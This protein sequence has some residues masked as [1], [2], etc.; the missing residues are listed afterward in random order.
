MNHMKTATWSLTRRITLG[1][2]VLLAVIFGLGG[3]ALLRLSA[4]TTSIAQVA[5]TTVPSVVMLD[6]V[7]ADVRDQFLMGPRILAAKGDERDRLQNIVID[8]EKQV[9]Q[10]LAQYEATLGTDP[11]ERKLFEDIKRAHQDVLTTRDQMVELSREGKNAEHDRMSNVVQQPNR[12]RLLAALSAGTA[13]TNRQGQAVAA[14]GKRAALVD[15]RTFLIVMASSIVI[16]AVMF[17]LIIVTTN[18]TLKEITASLERGAVQTASA[19]NQVSAS[20]HKLSAGANQQ[21]AAVE[22]TSTSLEEMLTMVRS[23]ADNAQKAKAL[24]SEARGTAESGL[25]TMGGMLEAMASIASAGQEVAKIVKNIDEIAFQTNILALNAAVEA[26]R[27]GEAGAGFAVV[28]DEVR[29]LAQRSAAAARDTSEK[30]DAAIASTVR[31]RE[32]SN[33]VRRSLSEISQNVNAPEA[34]VVEIA[35]A[36]SEQAQGIAQIGSALTQ[37]DRVSQSNSASAEQSA[38]AAEELNIQAETLRRSVTQLQ[39]LLGGT[40]SATG[41]DHSSPVALHA[42]VRPTGPAEGFGPS[43]TNRRYMLGDTRQRALKAI[44][45]PDDHG[46]AADSEDVNFTNF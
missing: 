4:L 27:A 40:V 46:A 8:Q 5:D 6:E 24:A 34:V 42:P 20:S 18:R 13:Y 44:P 16:A 43:T 17:Y 26:A 1:F 12:D 35:T 7:G 21:A 28:A 9:Q 45:M 3:F 11:E 10:L 29:S 30:I 32:C 25:Q 19:A 33:D 37:I 38:S 2:A 15:S 23:T 31:G 39:G 22:E 36:A 41:S 14:A